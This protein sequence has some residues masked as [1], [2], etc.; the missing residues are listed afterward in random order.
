MD[1]EWGQNLLRGDS[2]DS[3]IGSGNRSDLVI[4]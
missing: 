4:G 3:S 2:D 1:L